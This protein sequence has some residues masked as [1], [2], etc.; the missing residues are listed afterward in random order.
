MV[1]EAYN[2]EGRLSDGESGISTGNR[3]S[4]SGDAEVRVMDACGG[5][6]AGDGLPL[7]AG[8]WSLVRSR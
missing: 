1:F 8:V 6:I 7:P 5:G 3:K 4:G 2:T